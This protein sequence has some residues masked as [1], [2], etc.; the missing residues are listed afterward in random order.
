MVESS[1]APQQQPRD[2]KVKEKLGN[3]EIKDHAVAET[4]TVAACA[5]LHIV[6]ASPFF[7]LTQSIK[8]SIIPSIRK[9][10]PSNASKRRMD[11]LPPKNEHPRSEGSRCTQT[12]YNLRPHY[13][14][15]QPF[16]NR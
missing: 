1:L 8:H 15:I 16:L 12:S 7:L 6:R 11:L 14:P 3:V 5:L 10:T 4:P 9:Y 2:I 13:S